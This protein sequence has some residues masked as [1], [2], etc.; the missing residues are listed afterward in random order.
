MSAEYKVRTSKNPNWSVSPE[1]LGQ[2]ALL[3][4]NNFGDDAPTI[5]KLSGNGIVP[6]GAN[7]LL[8]VGIALIVG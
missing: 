4:K 5:Y 6:L 7:F 8:I 1:T 2:R 3:C